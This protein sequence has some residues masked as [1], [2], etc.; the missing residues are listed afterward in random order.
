M[1]NCSDPASRGPLA[2]AAL[3]LGSLASAGTLWPAAMSK[4]WISWAPDLPLGTVGQWW[5][6]GESTGFLED[7]HRTHCC[8]VRTFPAKSS[9]THPRMDHV[10]SFAQQVS[11][12]LDANTGFHIIISLKPGCLLSPA[13]LIQQHI[14]GGHRR[15]PTAQI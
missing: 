2:Q 7:I 12:L 6:P 5:S 11:N 4:F 3:E 1:R 9:G 15:R 14:A 8:R 13:S 10:L